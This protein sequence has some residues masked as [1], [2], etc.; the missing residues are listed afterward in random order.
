MS[1]SLALPFSNSILS[2][3]L[4]HA[5]TAVLGHVESWTHTEAGRRQRLVA[6]GNTVVCSC[7]DRPGSASRYGLSHPQL[8]VFRLRGD[9]S[10]EMYKSIWRQMFKHHENRTSRCVC[11]D[12]TVRV[13]VD[14]GSA[15]YASF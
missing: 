15:M 1:S 7:H 9:I 5:S 8:G 6:S 14:M 12:M 10:A 13:A 4:F 2:F 3:Q 11:P